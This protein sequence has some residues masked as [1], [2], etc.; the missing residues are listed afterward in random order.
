[1]PNDDSI[2]TLA[3]SLKLVVPLSVKEC[4][5]K[6]ES[7]TKK[8]RNETISHSLVLLQAAIGKDKP[9]QCDFELCAQKIIK[10][11]PELKDLLPPVNRS[12]FKQWVS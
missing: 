7:L 11:V 12:A 5:R 3:S 10:L 2:E 4:R 6:G 9:S 1:M 8:A